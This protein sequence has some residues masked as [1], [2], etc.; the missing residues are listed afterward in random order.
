MVINSNLNFAQ[1]NPFN[2]LLVNGNMRV[3]GDI[4]ISGNYKVSGSTIFI[5]GSQAQF[6]FDS[7]L[8]PENIYIA[9]N[10]IFMNT[11][12][13][14]GLLVGYTNVNLPAE[15]QLLTPNTEKSA[16]YVRQTNSTAHYTMKYTTAG[17]YCMTEH[18]NFTGTKNIMGVTPQNPYYVGKDISTPYLSVTELLTGETTVGIGTSG[19]TLNARTHIFSRNDTQSML[20]ITHQT[21]NPDTANYVSDITLEKIVSGST[22]NRWKIQGP[23]QA[24]QQKLQF[25]YSEQTSNVELFTFTK[26]GCFGIGNT[27]PTFAVDIQTTGDRG[28]IRMY[29]TDSNIAKPQLLFQSG[30]PTYGLD[31]AIDYRMY[32]YQNNFYLDMQQLSSGQQT[33]FH[34]TSNNALGILQNADPAYEVTIGGSLNIKDTLYLNGKTLFTYGDDILNQGL[35]IAASNIFLIPDAVNYGGV[36][37]NGSVPSCNLFQ[38][39]NGTNGNLMVLDSEYSDCQIHFR[40]KHN[41]IHRIWRIGIDGEKFIMEHA[42]NVPAYGYVDDSHDNYTRASEWYEIGSSNYKQVIFG[43]VELDH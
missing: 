8:N 30:H 23:N 25:L 36:L 7:N 2:T 14:R 26:E 43:S 17:S 27:T 42:D 31:E 18:R 13:L 12:S 5:A 19:S 38:I 11:A 28:G 39:N 1:Q 29:Q 35:S 16:V 33:L 40:N 9:G 15:A 22:A 10:D 37:I 3:I 34:F 32:S 4:D 41:L 6:A 20:H 21:N 24:Y